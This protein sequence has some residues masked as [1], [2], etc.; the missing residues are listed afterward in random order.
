MKRNKGAPEGNQNAAKHGAYSFLSRGN[1]PPCDKCLFKLEC[2]MYLKDSHCRLFQDIEQKRTA[3]IMALDHIRPEDEPLVQLYV[4]NH[5]LVRIIDLWC[6]KVS[7]FRGTGRRRTL[8]TQAVLKQRWVSENAFSRQADQLGLTP[9]SRERLGLVRGYK[10]GRRT[11]VIG[12]SE[13]EF[14][15]ACRKARSF[16]EPEPRPPPKKKVPLMLPLFRDAGSNN[17]DKSGN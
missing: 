17:N 4:R 5:C 9:A 14:I 10:G 12:G 2:D 13:Q 7:P 6:S 1:F 8:D 16:I 11:T 15:A 3:E